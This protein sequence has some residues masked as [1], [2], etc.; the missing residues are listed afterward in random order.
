MSKVKTNNA[1]NPMSPHSHKVRTGGSVV[2]NKSTGKGGFK[3]AQDS[4]VLG[5]MNGIMKDQY[6]K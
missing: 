1:S 3:V 6:N 4:T 2:A 5:T